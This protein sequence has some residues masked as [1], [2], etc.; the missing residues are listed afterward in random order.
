MCVDSNRRTSQVIFI[1]EMI[2][3]LEMG[4]VGWFIGILPIR[5]GKKEFGTLKNILMDISIQNMS[6]KYIRIASSAF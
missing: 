6:L 5:S 4:L 1:V 2:S 3:Q